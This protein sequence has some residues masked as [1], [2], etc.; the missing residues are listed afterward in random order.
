MKSAS[1][2]RRFIAVCTWLSRGVNHEGRN[3]RWWRFVESPS[4]AQI[5]L[6]INLRLPRYWRV[7]C[8]LS[9]SLFCGATRVHR[10]GNRK[11]TTFANVASNRGAR[12]WSPRRYLA[13]CS[14]DHAWWRTVGVVRR[15]TCASAKWNISRQPFPLVILS[16]RPLRIFE[17]MEYIFFRILR[18][19]YF[20]F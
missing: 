6:G 13:T 19:L 15:D 8:K 1:A 12:C 20:F 14:I 10:D 5:W 7:F 18:S 11:M 3:C 17:F 2:R 16:P 9:C 4:L